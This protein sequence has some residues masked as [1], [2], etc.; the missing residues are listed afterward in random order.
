MKDLDLIE[1]FRKDLRKKTKRKRR[2]IDEKKPFPIPK[3]PEPLLPKILQEDTLNHLVR[4][5]DKI[6]V[7]ESIGLPGQVLRKAIKNDLAELG[8][9]ASLAPKVFAMVPEAT[10]AFRRW[11]QKVPPFDGFYNGFK[12]SESK[13]RLKKFRNQRCK[14]KCIADMPMFTE[15]FMGAAIASRSVE[16]WYWMVHRLDTLFLR[17]EY[18]NL[19]FKEALQFE[20]TGD[21]LPFAEFIRHIG[22]KGGF[23]DDNG[24]PSICPDF[25]REELPGKWPPIGYGSDLGLDLGQF[26]LGGI[27]LYE[28]AIRFRL[29]CYSVLRAFAYAV[30][31]EYHALLYDLPIGS[32][33]LRSDNISSI[34]PTH[35]CKDELLTIEGES[36]GTS[37]NDYNLRL[38]LPFEVPG[39]GRI[40]RIAEVEDDHWTDTK[41]ELKCPDWARS[42]PI[43][44][45]D[46]QVLKDFTIFKE[47]VGD[48]LGV[49]EPIPGPRDE[50]LHQCGIRIRPVFS[51]V[52]I[53]VFTCPLLTEHNMFWGTI[54]EIELTVRSVE[55]IAILRDDGYHITIPLDGKI[56]IEWRV[57]GAL[58][59]PPESIKIFRYRGMHENPLLKSQFGGNEV[60]GYYDED[61]DES[62]DKN[63]SY[64][65]VAENRCAEVK[66]KVFVHLREPTTVTIYDIEVMQTIQSFVKGSPEKTNAI[67][68]IEGKETVVRIYAGS[69]K[70]SNLDDVTG[71]LSVSKEGARPIPITPY[72]FE[73]KIPPDDNVENVR[74]V[75]KFLLHLEDT[76][77]DIKLTITLKSTD[78]WAAWT[79][80]SFTRHVSFHAGPI[81][82]LYLFKVR[83][84]DDNITS[85]PEVD[86]CIAKLQSIFP[87]ALHGGIVIKGIETLDTNFNFENE[88]EFFD[89]S[90][91]SEDFFDYLKD[92]IGDSYESNTIYCA[93]LSKKSRENEKGIG[94][95]G[96]LSLPGGTGGTAFPM[97][98]WCAKPED[99]SYLEAHEIG[100]T[101]NFNENNGS[102]N[103][104]GLDLRYFWDGNFTSGTKAKDND[105][106]MDQYSNGRW[107]NPSEYIWIMKSI[108]AGRSF[109][110]LHN[111]ILEVLNYCSQNEL[112][113]D[114][115]VMSFE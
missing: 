111:R 76:R 49:S 82:N 61:F 91:R 60:F 18:I 96:G 55:E 64:E 69:G 27:N 98:Y 31:L 87:V 12:N 35:L 45:L 85:D 93:I 7:S 28:G 59:T 113:C 77:G 89:I 58:P 34:T 94:W 56:Y 3:I 24:F 110:A 17:N 50:E 5:T 107:I 99:D 6:N 80:V 46:V 11:L 21:G 16:D 25:G 86:T 29:E 10:S 14:A 40:C 9:I 103:I 43:G 88:S 70:D 39:Y 4:L 90:A 74:P 33:Y 13:E 105:Q 1:K 101:F 72:P 104:F 26:G 52:N 32:I 67:P 20:L 97:A 15:I 79:P 19:V 22:R 78:E 54:P 102:I 23:H 109:N 47:S 66:K 57:V 53:P 44:F 36:F 100:H 108:G 62:I 63:I 65:I 2:K 68:L 37:P 114:L 38:L 106:Q 84:G 42:G 71:I 92:Y 30:V 48:I 41:I 83:D 95:P 115:N 51:T 8:G 73:D 112:H 81:L 75:L